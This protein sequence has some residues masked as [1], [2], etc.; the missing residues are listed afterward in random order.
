MRYKEF[1]RNRVLKE[2]INLF[3]RQGFNATPISRIVA[4]TGV[5]R[6]SLYSE[7]GNKEGILYAAIQL[8]LER[9]AFKNLQLL[10]EDQA[11]P[12][13]LRTFFNAFLQRDE[14]YPRGC[15]LIYIATE[16]GKSNEEVNRVL[17]TYLNS[18]QQ[19]FFQWAQTRDLPNDHVIINQLVGLYCSAMCFGIVLSKHELEDYLTRNLNV[20][21]KEHPSYA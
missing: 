12:G 11:N 19:A 3:W 10:T 20:I 13:S 4:A 17:R 9:I 1:N 5:N 16:L 14:D 7:F 15:F 8:Y 6:F 21:L 2:C 18:L